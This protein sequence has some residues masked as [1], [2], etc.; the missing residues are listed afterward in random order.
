MHRLSLISV[1]RSF[2]GVVGVGMS[3]ARRRC[4]GRNLK[5]RSRNFP[6]SDREVYVEEDVNREH[7]VIGVQNKNGQ[8]KQKHRDLRECAKNNKQL[9]LIGILSVKQSWEKVG[10]LAGARPWRTLRVLD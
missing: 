7:I 10:V 9:S 5:R 2:S 3:P 8:I 6:Y 1:E 4:L